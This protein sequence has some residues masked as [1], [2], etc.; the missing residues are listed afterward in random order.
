MSRR[1]LTGAWV[2]IL[3]LGALYLFAPVAD[4][5]ADA[6]VGLP[7]DHA[8][9]F[10]AVAG[11]PWGEARRADPGTA[12]YITTLEVGYAVHELVFGLLFLAI[13]AIPFRRRERW[14]WWACW[15]VL[16]ANVTYALTF[17]R[18][19]ATILYRSLIAIIALPL[20][21]L[22]HTPAFFG[23]ARAR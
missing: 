20:L 5:R 3:L 7:A 21:L 1:I 22:A 9:T 15:A 17:G 13:V 14:A 11:V 2:L 18:H 19:D 16:L 12:R 4:L 6:S 23:R 8:G 10:A